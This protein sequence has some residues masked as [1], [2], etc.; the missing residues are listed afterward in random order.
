MID[1]MKR[2]SAEIEKELSQLYTKY[3]PHSLGFIKKSEL[4]DFS[5]L[6]IV[7]YLFSWPDAIGSGGNIDMITRK[8]NLFRIDYRHGDVSYA[9]VLKIIPSLDKHLDDLRPWNESEDNINGW[10]WYEIRSR[11]WLRVHES[12]W[13]SFNMYVDRFGDH[14]EPYWMSIIVRCLVNSNC[15]PIELAESNQQTFSEIVAGLIENGARRYTN[16]LI[17]DLKIVKEETYTRVTL[18]VE[19]SIPGMVSRDKGMTWEIGYTNH[20]FSSTY[21]IAAMFKEDQEKSWLAYTLVENPEAM[22]PIMCGGS[23]DI[24]QQKIESGTP[25]KNPFASE[26]ISRSITF[27]RDTIINYVV[28]FHY[29]VS[30]QKYAD[31]LA[32]RMMGF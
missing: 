19:P 3:Q 31:E 1:E 23:L 30:G 32:I 7:A 18:H 28:G 25:Y 16:L 2:I 27:D 14:I 6:D 29:G 20:V 11:C 24:V 4:A 5:G 15:T 10:F 8:G 13:D 9:D 12:I 21:A 26:K 17:K 22:I